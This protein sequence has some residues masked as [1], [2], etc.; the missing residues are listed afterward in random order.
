MVCSYC[1][2]KLIWVSLCWPEA[3]IVSLSGTCVRTSEKAKS[4]EKEGHW[5]TFTPW[6]FRDH[7]TCTKFPLPLY[8]FRTTLLSRSVCG[9]WNE[10]HF[11]APVICSPLPSLTACGRLL[12][13]IGDCSLNHHFPTWINIFLRNEWLYFEWQQQQQQQKHNLFVRQ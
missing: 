6:L 7:L 11:P 13:W 2:K 9:H 8:V 5:A 10:S 1:F 3:L 12:L 4:C